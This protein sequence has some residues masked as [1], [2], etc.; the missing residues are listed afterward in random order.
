MEMAL[1]FYEKEKEF[2]MLQKENSIKSLQLRNS[3][4][5]IVLVILGLITAMGIINFYYMGKR[6]KMFGS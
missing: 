3:Q 4:L 5:F 1:S 6:K 2:E